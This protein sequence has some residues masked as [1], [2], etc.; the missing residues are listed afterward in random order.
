ME[1][2]W[3]IV[4][5]APLRRLSQKIT[6]FAALLSTSDDLYRIMYICTIIIYICSLDIEGAEFPVLQTIPWDKVRMWVAQWYQTTIATVAGS[7][8]DT[9]Q[10]AVNC[11]CPRTKKN[12]WLPILL[13]KKF[14]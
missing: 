1:A 8:L 5:P 13:I 12:S 14:L 2:K 11:H 3:L 9:L 7:I 4:A 6:I 10:N